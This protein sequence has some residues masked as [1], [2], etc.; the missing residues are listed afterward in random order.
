M[1]NECVPYTV[2]DIS[3]TDMLPLIYNQMQSGAPWCSENTERMIM[4]H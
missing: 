1:K 2:R 4:A 3:V